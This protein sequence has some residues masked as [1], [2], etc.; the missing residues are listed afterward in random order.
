MTD[1]RTDKLADVL[2]NYSIGVKPDDWVIITGNTTGLP[3]IEAITERV[4]AAGA[5]PT[6][7][8]STDRLQ[9]IAIKHANDAQLQWTDPT[10]ALAA[11][12]V[13]GFIT[14]NA[15][16][17]T[18]ALTGIDPAR[19]QM[20]GLAMRPIL[21]Q[22]SKRNLAGELSWVTTNFPCEALA[23]EADM[24]LSEYEAFVYGATFA[25]QDDP[26]AAWQRVRDEQERLVNWL[27][28]KRQIEVRGPH[29]DMVL[30]IDGRGFIN[31]AGKNNMPSGEIFTSPVEDSA[32]G[33]VRFTYPAIRGGREVEGVEL[34]FKN[35]KVVKAS[36]NKNEGYL[37][38]QLDTDEGSRFLG[39]FA[40][41]TNYGIQRFTKSIL[42]DEKIGGTIHMAVGRGFPEIGGKNDS[43]VHWDF[44]CDMRE[45]SVILVD[46][47]I[48][49]KDGQFTV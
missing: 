41:G 22:F 19:Q 16:Q 6:V 29:I 1:P 25:D 43:V 42:F 33:W 18:R 2:V 27:Q 45:N 15:P 23:Q 30:S 17:N 7:R 13:N 37:I 36:A 46:G 26:V 28:G 5:H 21:Q 8:L 31:S 48:F 40:I 11:E 20:R 4:V 9:E 38:S 39:E 3:L 49:Y 10:I 34:H 44:I 47:V 32:E 24:S 12:K 35:G 14:I